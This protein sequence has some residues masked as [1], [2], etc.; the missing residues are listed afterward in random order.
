MTN[1]KEYYAEDLKVL[2]R[3]VSQCRNEIIGSLVYFMAEAN[4][5]PSGIPDEVA[6]EIKEEALKFRKNCECM[7]TKRK[8]LTG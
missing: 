5:Y 7:N 1:G 3:R 8:S 2:R 4:K 6:E